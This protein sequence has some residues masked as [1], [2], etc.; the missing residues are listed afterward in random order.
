MACLARASEPRG[1]RGRCEGCRLGRL[2]SGRTVASGFPTPAE[3][4]PRS[5]VVPGVGAVVGPGRPPG[6]VGKHGRCRNGA[7]ARSPRGLRRRAKSPEDRAPWLE[8]RAKRSGR[9]VR[10]SKRRAKSPGRGVRRSEHRAKR[11]GRRVQSS[12]RRAKRPGRRV[13]SSKRRAKSPGRRTPEPKHHPKCPEHRAETP[14]TRC[15][16]HPGRRRTERLRDNQ[17]LSR[18]TGSRRPGLP[19]RR[20]GLR[21]PPHTPSY[22]DP[23]R[24]P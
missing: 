24:P 20:P 15:F 5:R 8:H 10:S 1:R 22:K 7:G 13:Q 2:E 19:R 17:H 3:L 11:S 12:K 16:P 18:P 21:A 14:K 6:N 9:R 4:G 23:Q